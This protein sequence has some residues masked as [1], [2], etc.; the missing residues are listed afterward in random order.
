MGRLENTRKPA[1]EVAETPAPS[2]PVQRVRKA[3]EQVSDQLRELIETGALARGER[4]PTEELLA[5]QFG[6]S[7]ATVREA[8]RV[9]AAQNLIRT[10]KGAAGGSYVMLPTVD[11]ISEFLRMNIS[12]LTQSDGVTLDEFL[13]VRQLLEVNAARMA[14]RRASAEHLERLE[15]AIP[16]E[17]GKTGKT[18]YFAYNKEFHSTVIEACGNRL[19][20]I[21]AQ[22]LFSILQTHLGRSSLKRSFYRSVNDQHR[23][24]LE[25][26]REHDEDAAGEEMRRHIVFLRPAYEQTWRGVLK[27]RKEMAR[28]SKGLEVVG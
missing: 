8:L 26:I 11:H 4:L 16:A 23:L 19:M 21:T 6:V 7:R 18:D 13:E 20:Y 9:L 24:I 28:R 15:R 5:R 2:M 12:L 14:A 25:A 1:E 22:P 10:A 27:A 17:T 3:Y